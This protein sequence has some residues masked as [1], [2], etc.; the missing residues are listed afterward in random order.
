[1]ANN[2]RIGYIKNI[3]GAN[4][5]LRDKFICTGKGRKQNINPVQCNFRIQKRRSTAIV[6][7]QFNIG[8][9]NM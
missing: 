1:M 3:S 6:A 8:T 7:V 5:N 4:T 9:C 2:A